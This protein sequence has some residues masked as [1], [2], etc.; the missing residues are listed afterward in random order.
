MCD[1]NAKMKFSKL[2]AATLMCKNDPC[3]YVY[4][5]VVSM[6]I[7]VMSDKERSLDLIAYF[8]ENG[9]RSSDV[10]QDFTENGVSG[11]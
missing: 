1:T 7:P 4:V 2:L 5:F 10:E 8:N 11:K 6:V 9:I 3:V